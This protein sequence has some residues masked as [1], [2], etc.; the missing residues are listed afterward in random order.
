M[1]DSFQNNLK[2]VLKYKYCD[3]NYS[4]DKFYNPSR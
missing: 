3:S 2:F 4:T 1:I